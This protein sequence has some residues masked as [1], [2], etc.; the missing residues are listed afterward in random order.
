M[1]RKANLITASALGAITLLLTISCNESDSLVA[2]TDTSEG[3]ILKFSIADFGSTSSTTRSDDESDGEDYDFSAETT[4]NRLDLF[5]FEADENEESSED[6]SEESTDEESEDSE[7]EEE[8]SGTTY[9]RKYYATTTS[10]LSSSWALYYEDDETEKL[11]ASFFE[12]TDIMYLIANLP[13]TVDVTSI[14]SLSDLASLTGKMTSCRSTNNHFSMDA[15]LGGDET[16]LFTDTYGGTYHDLLIRTINIS[17]ERA[18][19]KVCVQVA[20]KPE[21][22]SFTPVDDLEEYGISFIMVN[23]AD[24]FSIIDSD[25]SW[26][27]SSEND[28]NDEDSTTYFDEEMLTQTSGDYQQAVFYICPNN[29]I[30][31]SKVADMK[32]EEPIKEEMQTHMQMRVQRM[33]AGTIYNHYYD[34]PINYLLPS[35]ND[36][37][38]I[39]EED[40]VDLYK[41]DRNHQY[42]VTVYVEQ[43]E[44]GIK[45]SATSSEGI[46]IDDLED[47]Y[48]ISIDGT[49]G[50]E[51]ISI[52]DLEDDDS[53]FEYYPASS[54]TEEETDDDT[55]DGTD[56]NSDDGTGNSDDGTDDNSDDGTDDSDDGTDGDSD[57]VTDNTDDGT[58]G[59]SD[60]VTDNSDDGTTED[61]DD[62]TD[63]DSDSSSE[64]E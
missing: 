1:K 8:E 16:D 50:V 42:N 43:S 62:V 61:S 54:E 64:E 48:T 32:S 35:N 23:Y 14:E 9:T 36:D 39:D 6:E 33:I 2:S 31:E 49:V 51:G 63:S 26:A 19:A 11:P 60:D 58:D 34:I 53:S 55:D 30:D 44:D 12:E 20:Y 3:L 21:G 18:L 47:A 37:Q 27:P 22:G 57:D 56:D 38:E 25:D 5:I 45:V 4:I 29:W 52:G 46:T 24:Q 13:D 7:S 10:N 17:L 15:S 41:A 59:D 28:L 40:Y